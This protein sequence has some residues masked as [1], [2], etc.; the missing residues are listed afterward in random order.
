CGPFLVRPPCVVRGERGGVL[1]RVARTVPSAALLIVVFGPVLGTV[2][3]GCADGKIGRS[4]AGPDHAA[5]IDGGVDGSI[6]T[7]GAS[8]SGDGSRTGDG[9]D[10]FCR[11][12]TDCGGNGVICSPLGQCVYDPCNFEAGRNL[13]ATCANRTHCAVTCL[14]VSDVCDGVVCPPSHTPGS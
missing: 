3:W 4:S 2:F 10:S 11:S 14:T 8:G 6:R 9:G 1:M 7:G 12:N 5:G 13:A